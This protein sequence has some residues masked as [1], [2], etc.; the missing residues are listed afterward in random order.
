MYVTLLHLAGS[1][2][3]SFAMADPGLKDFKLHGPLKELLE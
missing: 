1:P 2:R 3:D